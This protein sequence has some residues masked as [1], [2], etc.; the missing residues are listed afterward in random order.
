[1][2]QEAQVKEETFQE[3]FESLDG[4]FQQALFEAAENN[5]ASIT[6]E[7]DRRFFLHELWEKGFKF[8]TR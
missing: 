2:S 6:L 7:S 8:A 4:T 5:F 3:Y 1:M